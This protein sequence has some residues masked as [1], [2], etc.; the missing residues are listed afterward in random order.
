MRM[1]RADYRIRR[2]K[3]ATFGQPQ[4][5][6]IVFQSIQVVVLGALIGLASLVGL[7]EISE[8]GR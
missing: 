6:G 8:Q 3:I 5:E 7:C 2:D 1:T 4:D